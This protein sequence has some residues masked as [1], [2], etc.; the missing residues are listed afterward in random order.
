[1]TGNLQR[2]ICP[3]CV[4]PYRTEAT[5]K[6]HIQC[7]FCGEEMVPM[8]TWVRRQSKKNKQPGTAPEKE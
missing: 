4:D 3:R 6:S 1:M 8:V 7:T 5:D 2:Y